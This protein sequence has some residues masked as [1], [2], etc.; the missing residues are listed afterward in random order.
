MAQTLKVLAT[1]GFLAKTSEVPV[2][3]G[4]AHRLARGGPG[5]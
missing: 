3:L 1:P 5:R 4:L 2:P